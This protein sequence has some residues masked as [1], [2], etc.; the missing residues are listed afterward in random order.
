MSA[1]ADISRLRDRNRLTVL[2]LKPCF[3]PTAVVERLFT[4]EDK[5]IIF[6]PEIADL[7]HPVAFHLLDWLGRSLSVGPCWLRWLGGN[8]FMSLFTLRWSTWAAATCRWWWYLCFIENIELLVSFPVCVMLS[9]DLNWLFDYHEFLG[10]TFVT[11]RC[12]IWAMEDCTLNRTHFS[13]KFSH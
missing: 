1:C 9:L 2:Q 6:V 12:R 4:S 8:F 10:E 7:A 11:T 3:Y 5:Q 13:T